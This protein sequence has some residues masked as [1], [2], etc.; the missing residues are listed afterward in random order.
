MN[1]LCGAVWNLSSFPDNPDLTSRCEGATICTICRKWVLLR[2]ITRIGNTKKERVDLKYVIS[3]TYDEMSIEAAKYVADAIKAKPD[4][5]LG[6]P[7]GGTPVGM[8]KELVR[9]HNEEGLDFSKVRTFNLDEYLGLDSDHPQSYRYFMET[10]LFSHVNIKKENIHFLSGI[11]EDPNEE[12][13]RY[14]KAIADVGG[15]D[16]MILG[17][18]TNGHIGFNEPAN[19]LQANS[20]LVALAQSTIEANARFFEKKEDVPTRAVTMG[21]G[22]ILRSKEIILLASGKSKQ[23]AIYGTT[24]GVVTLDLPASLLQLHRD[25]TLF[26][27]E[28]AAAKIKK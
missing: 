7:T 4:I 18:G 28:E 27:D 24:N 8:Y 17:I 11:A 9:L 22:S 14:E 20:H 23:D 25:V 26:L 2:R 5:V 15:I 21:V 12:C 10:N 13:L 16:L 1:F 6:L 3:S 19:C